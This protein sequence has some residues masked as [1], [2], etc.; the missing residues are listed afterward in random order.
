VREVR[1]VCR[2]DRGDGFG[3]S[4]VAKL[5][6]R[7]RTDDADRQ[8][9]ADLV[10]EG[11]LQQLGMERWRCSDEGR[12]LESV[13]RAQLSR[14]RA[15]QII[16]EIMSRAEQVN[17]DGFYAFC[18][19]SIVAFGSYLT[20]RQMIGDIDL[21]V[22]LRPRFADPNDQEAAWKQARARAV[23]TRNL[24][25][26]VCWPQTEVMRALKGRSSVVDVHDMYEFVGILRD[27][28]ETR[29][30]VLFGVWSPQT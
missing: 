1:A 5:R 23:R 16:K 17:N 24:S 7:E 19:D 10:R 29:Y 25:E 28:P 18:V 6:L 9:L 12:V 3:L 27:C 15:D 21:V 4:E 22:Q 2:L 11:F 20:E 30:K 26:V 13:S 14:A 8:F